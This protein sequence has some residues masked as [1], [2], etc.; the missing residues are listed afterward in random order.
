MALGTQPQGKMLDYEQ[1]IDHQLSR[2]QAKIKTTDILIASLTLATGFIFVL[3]LEIVLDH[4]V[5]LPTW[6]R[7]IVLFSGLAG[8]AAYSAFRIALPSLRRVNGLYAAKTIEDTDPQ[9]KNSLISYLDLRKYR[10]ELP[11][12]V[13]RAIEAKAVGDLTKVEVETV[14]NQKRLLHTWYALMGAIMVVFIYYGFA[15]K[16]VL[17]SAKRAFLSDVVRPTNTRLEITKPGPDKTLNEVV[18]GSHVPFE[19]GVYGVRPEKVTLHFSTDGGQFYLEQEF[20]PGKQLFDPWQTQIRN[21]Q[22]SLDYYVTGGDAESRHYRVK[23]L[24]AP[25][26]NGVRLDFTFPSYTGVPPRTGIEG[27]AIDA[28]EGTSVTVHAK[29]NQPASS[30][31]LDLGKGKSWAMEISSED[32]QDLTGKIL[33]DADGSYTIKFKTTG[34]Q[35]NPDPVVYDVRAIKD[36]PPTVRFVAPEPRIKLP[37][38]GKVA[39]KIDAGDDFGV[40]SLDLKVMQSSEMLVSRDLLENKD[41]PR[42]FDGTEILDLSGFALKPGTNVEYWLVARDTKEPSSNVVSTDKQVLEIVAPLKP[43]ELAKLDEKIQKENPPPPPDD[44]PKGRKE[45]VEHQAQNGQPPKEDGQQGDQKG[46]VDQ[47]S[48]A[49]GEHK[50]GDDNRPNAEPNPPEKPL[51]AEDQK[52]LNDIDA[53]LKKFEEQDAGNAGKEPQDGQQTNPTTAPP[54]TPPADGSRPRPGKNDGGTKSNNDVAQAPKS[55]QPNQPNSSSQ[56]KPAKPSPSGSNPDRNGSNEVS[57]ADSPKNQASNPSKPS[58]TSKDQKPPDSKSSHPD[59][60]GQ[61]NPNPSASDQPR[62]PPGEPKKPEPGSRDQPQNGN[63]G[64]PQS[65][66]NGDQP[67]T[68]NQ[69]RKPTKDDPKDPGQAGGQENPGDNQAAGQKGDDQAKAGEQKPSGKPGER[70]TS[71][72]DPSKQQ[73]QTA[74]KD[75]KPAGEQKPGE[76]GARQDGRKAGEPGQSGD[77]QPSNNGD[78]TESKPGEPKDKQAAAQPSGKTGDSKQSKGTNAQDQKPTERKPDDPGH[79]QGNGGDLQAGMNG[80][81]AKPKSDDQ[82]IKKPGIP[83]QGQ[84]AGQQANPGDSKKS[85]S[86]D[87]D[88]K[89]GEPTKGNSDGQPG[90]SGESQEANSADPNKKP[91]EAEA[92]K[93]GKPQSGKPG[94]SKGQKS[95]NPDSKSSGDR[96]AGKPGEDQPGK[97]GDKP[98]GE[99]MNGQ[100]KPDDASK[101]KAGDPGSAKNGDNEPGKPGDPSARNAGK[102]QAK[103]DGKPQPGQSVEPAKGKTDDQAA[104]SDSGRARDQAAKPDEKSGEPT[105]GKP[106]ET[107]EGK[108]TGEKSARKGEPSSVKPKDQPAGKSDDP[109]QSKTGDPQQPQ[110]GDQ[111]SNR[112][113]DPKDPQSGEEPSFKDGGQPQPKQGGQ[114]QPKQGGQ[115]QPK[116]GGQPQ[117]KSDNQRAAEDQQTT[118][119]A[120]KRSAKPEQDDPTSPGESAATKGGDQAKS[121]SGQGQAKDQQGKQGEASAKAKPGESP[122]SKSGKESPGKPGKQAAQSKSGSREQGESGDPMSGESGAKS[123]QSGDQPGKAEGNE[124]KPGGQSGKSGDSREGQGDAPGKPGGQ[125]GQGGKQSGGQPSSGSGNEPGKS[126]KSSGKPGGQPGQGDQGGQSPNGQDQAES[127]EMPNSGG[128]VTG[129]GGKGGSDPGT[130]HFKDNSQPLP[131]VAQKSA[132]GSDPSIAPESAKPN[133]VLRKLQDLLK[134]D[135]FTPDVEKKIGMSREEAEQFVKKFENRQQPG[136]AGPGRTIEAKPEKE[137]VFDPNRPAPKFET[138]AISSNSASR[139]G[140]SIPQDNLSG[141]SE[142]GKSAPPIELRKKFEAYMKGVANA[143]STAP[144]GPP[145]SNR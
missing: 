88:K 80:E 122:S 85:D 57:R 116:Q 40:K 45:E 123:N 81:D 67:P 107:P 39:L 15:P 49:Q 89:P 74:S 72:A 119:A 69:E 50:P 59:Q 36:Q 110:A 12:R 124:G 35:M 129:R 51:S 19:V 4:A 65:G 104:N 98:S 97:P 6:V 121:K 55:Q 58:G 64:A 56:P 30:A 52:Q 142:G 95:P 28:I 13:L 140:T 145:A 18:A 87:P 138:K 131:P 41:H 2:T 105:E 143:K 96:Q 77:P 132:D 91:G 90:K 79:P 43:E 38:N 16:S 22:Q 21:V 34:G 68:K 8:M 73:G 60:S 127:N 125:P 128:N 25:M 120:E 11:K 54:P 17:D 63:N 3:F 115:P 47:T 101:E 108:P 71:K 136:P 84:A 37:S 92:G 82:P 33:V 94:D 75:R 46:G 137:R 61:S 134:D 27:G 78:Q 118:K 5:G 53:K 1:F 14:V 7:R 20:A 103:K 42:K 135:K 31:M 24:P 102:P 99:A 76:P 9:F 126:G 93:P 23:V 48:L 29:T 113:S 44:Q 109:G 32:P 70:G 62:T 83:P 86:A 100:G 66:S 141:L 114:P 144:S 112:T 10:D 106:G 139:T 130:D 26:V 133:L 117:S 111:P